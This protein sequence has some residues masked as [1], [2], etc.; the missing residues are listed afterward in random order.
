MKILA[1][2]NIPKDIVHWLRNEKHDVLLA[3]EFHPGAA[4]ADWVAHAAQ[5][6]RLILASDKDF[7]ELIFRDGLTSQGIALLRMDDLL[8]AE[9][10]ARIQ[11][12][13][14]IVEANPEG[15][16]IVITPTK[17]RVRPFPP[18]G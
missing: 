14:S 16:F 10:L 3:A 13:W 1:D 17:V 5:E 9:M 11:D 2:E 6:Q 18:R 12:T 7:G 15:Q 8:P 4:D